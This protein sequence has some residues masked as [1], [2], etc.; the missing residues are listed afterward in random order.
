MREKRT[1][2][3]CLPTQSIPK[4]PRINRD[5]HKTRL[6]GA[7]PP[8]TFCDLFGRRKMEKAVAPVVSGAVI[9]PGRDGCLPNSRRTHVIDRSAH[10]IR[11]PQTAAAGEPAPLL[12]AGPERVAGSMAPTITVRVFPP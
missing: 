6:P 3:R 10:S 11:V 5:Q 7:M 12:T 8:G 1:V 4:Q 2:A 9:P